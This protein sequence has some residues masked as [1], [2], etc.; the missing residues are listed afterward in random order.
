MSFKSF[1]FHPQIESG[2]GS[3]GYTAP[4]PIQLQCI[5]LIFQGL[6]VM[7]LA[8]T[9]AGKPAAVALPRLQR[10][11]AGPRRQ[12]RALIIVPA[13]EQSGGFGRSFIG[14]GRQGLTGF[15]KPPRARRSCGFTRQG[16]SA[17]GSATT[18]RRMVPKARTFSVRPE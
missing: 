3:F 15:R 12:L 14:G 5:P 7:G 9:G 8:Q 13:P 17:S 1:E 18:D 10:W 4:T 11:M 2:I 6:A 16:A